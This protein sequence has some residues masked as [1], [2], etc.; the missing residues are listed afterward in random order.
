MVLYTPAPRSALWDSSYN[1]DDVNVAYSAPSGLASVTTG[2]SGANG[3]AVQILGPIA[4]SAGYLILDFYN[5]GT[6]NTDTRS[7][8]D[9]LIDRAGGTSWDTTPLVPDVLC[10]F[11]QGTGNAGAVRLGL[12]LAVPAGASLGA[13]ARS[14]GSARPL[15]VGITVLS[16]DA[17]PQGVRV[18]TKAVVLGVRSADLNG[19]LIAGS[20]TSNTWS[21]FTD[22]GAP[23][24]SDTW[25]MSVLCGGRDSNSWAASAVVQ[26]QIGV[27]GKSIWQSAYFYCNTSEVIERG[28]AVSPSPRVVPAGS[29]MQVRMR[30]DT[31]NT[32][33][34]G[35]AI[36]GVQ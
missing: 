17:V 14:I 6:I 26:P 10:G 1:D 7:L 22:V 12:P 11:T 3:T 13:Q 5:V 16:A 20:G 18:G 4:F 2:A 29:Q 32:E 36:Y 27:D 9:V 8:F 28:H 15:R 31:T 34:F 23:L 25:G 21:A 19:T 33:S 24:Q 30:R 35:F